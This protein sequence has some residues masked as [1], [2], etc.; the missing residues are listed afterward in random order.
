[1]SEKVKGQEKPYP[2]RKRSPKKGNLPKTTNTPFSNTMC[3]TSLPNA[4]KTG[5]RRC[6]GQHI[7]RRKKPQGDAARNSGA[8]EDD[9]GEDFMMYSLKV[10]PCNKTVP[11]E[12][13]VC[14]FAH[15]GEGAVRRDLRTY[16]YTGVVC[17]DMKKNGHCP[18]G[19]E[20]PFA[21]CVFEYWLHPTR[22]RTVMCT[23]GDKCMRTFCFFA[24]CLE[25][26]RQPEQARLRKLP[27][28]RRRE[29]TPQNAA[30]QTS[31]PADTAAYDQAPGVIGKDVAGIVVV[32]PEDIKRQLLV[33]QGGS[34]PA[35]G[36][37][38][39]APGDNMSTY[40]PEPLE[41]IG[42]PCV[43]PQQVGMQAPDIGSYG[44]TA[45][46]AAPHCLGD[47]I[48]MAGTAM[49]TQVQ[50]DAYLAGMTHAL[51]QRAA[52]ARGAPP[53]AQQPLP[54]LNQHLQVPLL[55]HP[56]LQALAKP[57][58]QQQPTVYGTSL[59]EQ[60]QLLL[61]SSW[62]GS[63][64]CYNST[65]AGMELS[66][67]PSLQGAPHSMTFAP[68]THVGAVLPP[69]QPFSNNTYGASNTPQINQVDATN[70]FSAEPY[71]LPFHCTGS[72]DQMHRNGALPDW[73]SG[74]TNSFM[75]AGCNLMEAPSIELEFMAGSQEAS[76]V[77]HAMPFHHGGSLNEHPSHAE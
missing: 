32:E 26:L 46:A 54:Q 8:A 74:S 60:Q 52:A 20:C 15:Q 36:Q 25:E 53:G 66:D 39:P 69:V 16:Y 43:K 44:G 2:D 10:I 75:E 1:M 19:D 72:P 49:Q 37:H 56:L 65:F 55:P 71:L 62:V 5:V 61:G 6:P 40:I 29:A 34:P 70:P 48:S 59:T 33:T 63:P 76:V 13:S 17:P 57:P 9:H 24:H 30:H 4:E 18:R 38:M 14:P 68:T 64:D 21:H 77:L 42:K 28:Q 7:N 27:R 31:P 45:A 41:F 47:P 12:W 50:L 58:L 51:G 35:H 22:F 67:F 23:E 73:G 3:R 11:H